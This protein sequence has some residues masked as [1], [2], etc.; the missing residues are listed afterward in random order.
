MHCPWTTPAITCMYSAVQRLASRDTGHPGNES[1]TKTTTLNDVNYIHCL[2]LVF[3]LRFCLFCLSL[4]SS[5]LASLISSNSCRAWD[6]NESFLCSKAVSMASILAIS[7]FKSLYSAKIEGGSVYFTTRDRVHLNVYD[8][9]ELLTTH[10]RIFDAIAAIFGVRHFLH[11][12]L[13]PFR[14]PLCRP[15]VYVCAEHTLYSWSGW[16][17]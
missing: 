1:R 9:A 10:H 6:W 7:R 16:T 14:H 2:S 13:H 12:T 15:V 5:R 17:Y 11:R 8:E 3:S 4:E